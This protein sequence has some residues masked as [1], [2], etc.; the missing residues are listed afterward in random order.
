MNE[1]GTPEPPPRL[2]R[3]VVEESSILNQDRL[4]VFGLDAGMVVK[5]V[6]YTYQVLDA[7]DQTTTGFGEP[8]LSGLLELA[9]LSSVIGNLFGRGLAVAS[10]GRFERN[11]PHAYPDLL[12]RDPAYRDF[13]V[14]VALESNKPKGHLPKPGPHLTIRYVLGDSAGRFTRGKETRGDVVWIWEVRVGT[15]AMEHF[16]V[17]NTAGDSG[18][19]AVINAAGMAE[20]APVLVSLEHCPHSSRGRTYRELYTLIHGSPP[21]PPPRTRRSP[22]PG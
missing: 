18:K 12:A 20:L 16:Q 7:I 15:L 9:N 1:S 5:A 8:R 11:R 19:T 3:R 21:S 4:R 22:G 17:S 13:E 6:A 2:V 10:I 14:K